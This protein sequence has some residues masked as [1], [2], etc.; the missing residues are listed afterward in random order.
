VFIWSFLAG[1]LSTSVLGTSK[2]EQYD[3][4][5]ANLTLGLLIAW[6]SWIGAWRIA[7]KV[8]DTIFQKTL[9]KTLHFTTLVWALVIPFSLAAILI[10]RVVQG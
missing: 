10:V 8:L 6:F 2:F 9:T 1:A 4:R 5:T 7:L 3:L